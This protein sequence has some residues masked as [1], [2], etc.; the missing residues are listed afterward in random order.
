MINCQGAH[1]R[2]TQALESATIA[3][4]KSVQTRYSNNQAHLLQIRLQSLRLRGQLL[5]LRLRRDRKGDIVLAQL[6]DESGEGQGRIV[7][8]A[9]CPVEVQQHDNRR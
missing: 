5:V 2:R 1:K 6:L 9:V 8:A 3:I 4:T 7:E